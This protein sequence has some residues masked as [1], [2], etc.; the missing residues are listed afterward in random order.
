MLTSLAPTDPASPTRATIRGPSLEGQLIALG[1]IRRRR[2][3]TQ[4]ELADQSGVHVATIIRL[5]NNPGYG[6]WRFNT[7]QAL[8]GVLGV[9]AHDLLAAPGPDG[10]G[11]PDVPGRLPPGDVITLLQLAACLRTNTKNL[12]RMIELRPDHLPRQMPSI[13]SRPRWSR[14]VVERWLAGDQTVAGGP[15]RR[16]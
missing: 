4:Q 8:A 9:K 1:D 13:D 7:L 15:H 16:R 14:A 5:E 3:L 6:R 2:G 12:K 10:D 11:A